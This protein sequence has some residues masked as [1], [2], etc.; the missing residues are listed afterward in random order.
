M[1]GDP[2]D[3]KTSLETAMS[4]VCP[5]S[6]LSGVAEKILRMAESPTDAQTLMGAVGHTNRTRFRSA[7]MKP[8]MDAGLLEPTIPDKP[9]SSKLKYRLTQKGQELMLDHG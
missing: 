9:R 1:F 5:K 8:L 3:S 6:V 2:K 7:I 4:Q